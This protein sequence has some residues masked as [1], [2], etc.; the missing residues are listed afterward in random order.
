M[1][2]LRLCICCVTYLMLMASARSEPPPDPLR[3]IPEQADLMV[4]IEQPRRLVEAALNSDIVKQLQKI[5]AVRELYNSSNARQLYQFLAYFEKQLGADRYELLDRLAGGGVALGVKFEEQAPAVLVIQSKDEQLL[6]RF[7]KLAL[8]AIE[9]ELARQESKDKIEKGTYRGIEGVKIGE[10]LYAAIIGSALVIANKDKALK[11]VIDLHLDGSK[12]SLAHLAS[13]AEARK[14]VGEDPLAWGWLNLETVRKLPGAKDVFALPNNQPVLTVL[15]G[16]I[17]DVAR[18][19][20]FLCAG[21]YAQES[22]FRVSFRMPRGSEGMPAELA[23]HRPG[24]GEPGSRPLLEPKGVLYSSSFFL[25]AAKFWEHRTKLVNEAQLK[26]LEEF[27]KNSGRFLAGNQMSKLL[28]QLGAYQRLVVTHQPKSGY[29][30]TPGQYTPAFA[31]VAEMRE[32]EEAG[33]KLETILRGAALLATT[34]VKLTLVEEK[35]GQHQIVGY[36]FPE[37]GTFKIDNNNIRFNFSPCFVAVGN[38]FVLSSTIEL[39]HELIDLL[40]KEAK[41]T[42]AQKGSSATVRTQIYS[43]G[44][45]EALTAFKDQLFTQ[46]ILDQAL[47]PEKAREQVQLFS[48]WVRRLGVLQLEVQYGAKD[49]RYDLQWKLAE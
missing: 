35:R 12:K 18:R 15:F 47:P 14:V 22:G 6:R 25:D 34:Q 46:I 2:M 5:D 3:L 9:Q 41:Q 17:L 7:V 48:D 44:G 37:D 1:H 36:R 24:E 11:P 30:I 20:P 39:C 45:A 43:A 19:S 10:N 40:E 49:F 26:T 23:L 33:K 29:K 28:T 13:V 38:Q 16:G 4:K 32:P 8:E 31:L 42:A 27:D 21:V